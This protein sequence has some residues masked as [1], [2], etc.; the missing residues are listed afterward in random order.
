VPNFPEGILQIPHQ[1]KIL[2]FLSN[3][4]GIIH[5]HNKRGMPTS[6]TD[7]H[8]YSALPEDSCAQ[9]SSA[10]LG[11]PPVKKKCVIQNLEGPASSSAPSNNE[12]L[13]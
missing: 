12:I 11:T 2:S 8:N 5:Q 3:E 4:A 6:P 9:S 10:S 13:D 1:Q 7:E